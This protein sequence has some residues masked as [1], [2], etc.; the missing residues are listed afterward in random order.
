MP[1]VNLGRVPLPGQGQ[2][3]NWGGVLCLGKD[4]GLTGPE[5]SAWAGAGGKP[6]SA[7]RTAPRDSDPAPRTPH[8]T[9]PHSAPHPA[10]RGTYDRWRSAGPVYSESG[11]MRAFDASCSMMW[12]VQPTTRDATKSG[13]NVSVSNPISA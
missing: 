5:S 2:R 6:H 13:V 1:R 10:P 11:R 9:S 3:A 8:R 4:S 12:A 7:H